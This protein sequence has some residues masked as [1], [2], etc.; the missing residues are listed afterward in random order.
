M[1]LDIQIGT[2]KKAHIILS[3]FAGRDTETENKKSSK[4]A[5]PKAPFDKMSDAYLFAFVLGLSKG[6]KAE[7]KSRKNYAHIGAVQQGDVDLVALLRLLGDPKDL[8]SKE[9]AKAA[10]EEY[11][12]W[13]LLHLAEHHTIG[14]DDYRLGDLFETSS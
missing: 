5:N 8:E 14:N 3:N 6:E 1:I 10:I 4:K 2:S 7:V 9:S 13:G 12:T 11:A